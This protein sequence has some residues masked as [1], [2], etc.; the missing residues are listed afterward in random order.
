[1]PT[2]KESHVLHQRNFLLLWLAQAISMFGDALTSLTLI[3][4]INT[5]TRSTVAVAALTIIIALPTILVGLFAGVLVDRLNRKAILLLSDLVRALLLLC[6]LFVSVSGQSLLLI[7]G[8]AFLEASVGTFFAP[9]RAAL[10]QIIV[11]EEQFMQA[12]AVSQTS[13]VIAQLAGGTVAGLLLGFSNQYWPAFLLDA[14]T[15]LVSFGLVIG[16]RATT[17]QQ[18]TEAPQRLLWSLREG[19]QSLFQSPVLIAIILIFSMLMFCFGPIMVLMIP[20]ISNILHVPTAWIGIIQSGDT[21]GNIIG[22]IVLSI[23][24]AH[25]RPTRLL[26]G[27]IFLLGVLIAAIGFVFHPALLIL[28]LFLIGILFVCLQTAVGT[29]MQQVIS[30]EMMGRISSMLEILPAVANIISMA[31]AGALGALVGIRQVF[32][33]VGTLLILTGVSAVFLLRRRVKEE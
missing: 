17:E 19:F 25:L 26:M 16:V 30:N 3:I 6:L 32:V 4:W 9:A 14:L 13:I 10:V 23:I 20:F 24:A 5:L 8:L 21:L 29:I 22:G 18:G 15:F 28:L 27:S 7:Y 1:M 31:F 11:R 12:N 33:L 2:G